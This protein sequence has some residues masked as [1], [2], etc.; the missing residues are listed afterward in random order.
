MPPPGV[1]TLNETWLHAALKAWYAEPGDLLEAAVDG[2]VVDIVR[3]DRLIEIQ[4]GQFR[5]MR[6]KL[7]HLLDAHEVRIVYPIAAAKWIVKHP[8]GGRPGSRRR[9]PRAGRTQDLFAELVSFPWLL[10]HPNLSIEVVM[11]EQEEVRRYGG[12]SRR[13]RGWSV[14][15]RRLLGVRD[16]FSVERPVDLLALLPDTLPQPFTTAELALALGRP[17][18]LA[19][20]MAYCLRACA[21]VEVVGRQGNT[22][23]Y[24]VAS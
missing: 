13:R 20:Q 21:L 14:V 15:D 11:T 17:R 5:A 7:D 3:G 4:T 18:R 10:D 8:H 23:V 1:G 12:R 16:R 6:R 2:F 22:L 24:R 9:S 19:Q